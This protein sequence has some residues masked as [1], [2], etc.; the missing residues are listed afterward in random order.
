MADCFAHFTAAVAVSHMILL[1]ALLHLYQNLLRAPKL[2]LAERWSHYVAASHSRMTEA[3]RHP[4]TTAP[5]IPLDRPQ[6]PWS[7]VAPLSC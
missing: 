1:L 3:L 2:N 7:E 6:C 5:L 4:A